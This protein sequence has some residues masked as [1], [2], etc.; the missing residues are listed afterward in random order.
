MTSTGCS[1]TSFIPGGCP[2]RG[3]SAVVAAGRY[4]VYASL[5]RAISTRAAIF[6]PLVFGLSLVVAAPRSSADQIEMQNGDRYV[7]Q[8]MAFTNDTV[9]LQSDLLGAIRLP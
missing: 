4:P 6:I 7:G 5:M 1:Q 9:V 8:V 2:N 3:E